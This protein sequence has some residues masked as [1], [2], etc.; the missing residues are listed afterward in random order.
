MP[1]KSKS[2]SRRRTNRGRS[3]PSRNPV[4]HP[5]ADASPGLPPPL[6][7]ANGVP[8]AAPPPPPGPLNIEGGSHHSPGLPPPLPPPLIRSGHVSRGMAAGLP[9]RGLFGTANGNGGVGINW[10]GSAALRGP[11]GSVSAAPVAGGSVGSVS[12]APVAGGPVTPFGRLSGPS[13][14]VLRARAGGPSPA[15]LRARA[16]APSSAVGPGGLPLVT[17]RTANEGNIP[18]FL[19]DEVGQGTPIGIDADLHSVREGYFAARHDNENNNNLPISTELQSNMPLRPRANQGGVFNDWQYGR[20]TGRVSQFG[21]GEYLFPIGQIDPFFSTRPTEDMLREIREI[22]RYPVITQA[23]LAT[24]DSLLWQV[25]RRNQRSADIE[26]E[27]QFL[28]SQSRGLGER[29]RNAL[30]SSARTTAGGLRSLWGRVAG[31][32]PTAG[33]RA[34]SRTRSRSRTPGGTRRSRSRTPGGTRRNGN[35]RNG[36]RR[37]R[38]SGGGAA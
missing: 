9:L 17:G 6:Q 13:P 14:A 35:R 31:H 23:D 15:V 37:N 29:I 27:I 32:L 12:A 25:N 33:A 26:N 18:F 36:S 24:V 16:G 1:S 3:N 20:R 19:I 5:S 34:P 28:R 11:G 8:L 38:G 10:A 2:G 7:R 4:G 21:K 30:S 22:L